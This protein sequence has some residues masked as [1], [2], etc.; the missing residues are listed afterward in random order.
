MR[1][2]RAVA[3]IPVRS[4]KETWTAIIDL[5]TDD[6]SVDRHQ[7][8]AATS[9]MES[10]IADELPSKVPIVFKGGGPRILI[11]CL[12]QEDAMEAGLAIDRLNSNPT[13]GDWSVT[14]PCE[15]ADQ[16]WMNKTLK[17]RAPRIA[18][19]D[20]DEP[21]P[22]ESEQESSSAANAEKVFQVDWEVLNKR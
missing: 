3:S 2:R 11:Y 8:V 13:A 1:I 20:V 17:D 9:I 12:Y 19:H 6:G 21:P 18:V 4:A 16:E 5:V 14:A 15:E 7:L 10:L 22:D